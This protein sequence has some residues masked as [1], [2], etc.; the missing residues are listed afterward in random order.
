ML[1]CIS[2]ALSFPLSVFFWVGVVG[3]LLELSLLHLFY[4]CWDYLFLFCGRLN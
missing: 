1:S 3:E 4:Q 2:S